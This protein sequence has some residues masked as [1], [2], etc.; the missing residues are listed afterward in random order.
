MTRYCACIGFGAVAGVLLFAF[1][2]FVVAEQ[3][4]CQLFDT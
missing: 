4:D 1:L 2:A 3:F